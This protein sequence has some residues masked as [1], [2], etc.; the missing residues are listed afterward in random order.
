[1]MKRL[2]LIR[3]LVAMVLL[4]TIGL[5]GFALLDVSRRR[6]VVVEMSKVA[7]LAKL[8]VAT[9]DLIDGLER[10]RGLVAGLVA[11]EGEGVGSQL[12][13]ERVRT[14]E[15]VAGFDQALKGAS[16]DKSSE[17]L[18]ELRDQVSDAV[19]R[20]RAMR[21]DVDAGRV[22]ALEAVPVYSDLT[23]IL[24][25]VMPLASSATTD[26][27]IRGMLVS[28]EYLVQV[29]MNA[30]LERAGLNLACTLGT[31]DAGIH[32]ALVQVITRQEVYQDLF[33]THAAADHAA[34]LQATL[35]GTETQEVESL[36]ATA[37]EAVE[38]GELGISSQRWWSASSA[39]I[40]ALTNTGHDVGQSVIEAAE[41]L[42]AGGKRNAWISGVFTMASILAAV[43][44]SA[45]VARGLSR[46]LVLAST[47]THEAATQILSSVQQLTASISET[48]TA[49][50]QTST[51]VDEIRQ[52]A[53]VAAS[54]AE[55]TSKVANE[56][57]SA[58]DNALEAVTQGQQAM[59]S[60]R[61]GVEAIA[62]NI[63]DLSQKTIRIGEIV[64]TVKAIAEQSNLLAVNASIEAAK[65]GEQGKGFA[66]VANEVKTLAL[67]SK[68]AT[69]EIRSIL[70]EIERSANGAVMI[71]EQ[72]VNRVEEGGGLIE[73]LGQAIENLA[74]VIEENSDSASQIA[75]TATQQLTGIE[76]INVALRNVEAAANDNAAGAHQLEKVAEQVMV[77]RAW[78]SEI[79]RGQRDQ[80]A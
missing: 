1:M 41:G 57:R 66:V 24:V 10:E 40:E 17:R 38:S 12:G 73:E 63:V 59:G 62:E 80:E 43:L 33:L 14:D 68:E 9:S 22:S 54:R 6:G 2:T 37:T 67:R 61:G 3:K 47:K 60:I 21:V 29:R 18:A 19:E 76:Q 78:L 45:F 46:P 58:S 69:E 4:P 36:R 48:A 75:L 44:F 28:L 72:G 50:T 35:D 30:G 53:S 7:G 51:T 77:V 11:A 16:L 42:R 8:A 31:M 5:V 79:V 56:S 13:L 39:R 26:G 20:L 55:L 27:R 15:L 74:R 23:A 49:I 32:Q 64:E 52:T 71:T 70:A 25:Q 65:A 34:L